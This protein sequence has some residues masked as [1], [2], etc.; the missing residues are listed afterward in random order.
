MVKRKSLWVAILLQLIIA[1]LGHIYLGRFLRG[2]IFILVDLL[3]SY[4]YFQEESIPALILSIIITIIAI[5]DSYKIANEM[6]KQMKI[7]KESVEEIP[8][9]YI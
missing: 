3:T 6:S 2:A 4:I 8:E 7:K 5:Y 1:G 9:V